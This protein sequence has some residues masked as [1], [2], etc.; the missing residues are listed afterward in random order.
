MRKLIY[1]LI[2]F[3]V[4]CIMVGTV[5]AWGNCALIDKAN[6]G[7]QFIDKCGDRWTIGFSAQTDGQYPCAKGHL[8]LVN[9]DNGQKIQC[10][11]TELKTSGS[12]ACIFCGGEDSVV[13]VCVNPDMVRFGV[14]AYE[15]DLFNGNI[16]VWWS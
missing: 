13:R 7:G 9:H 5:S 10:K 14:D 11:V 6:G 2:A 15:M 16:K 4:L 1:V 3:A 8:T 12:W